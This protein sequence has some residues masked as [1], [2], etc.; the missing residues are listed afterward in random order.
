MVQL[1]YWGLSQVP[2]G[3][4][5]DPTGFF[6]SESHQEALARMEYLVTNHRRVGIL[7]GEPGSGKSLTLEVFA[8]AA[9]KQGAHVTQINLTSLTADEFL[10]KLAVGLGSHPS[11]RENIVS[12]WRRIQDQLATLRYQRI[13]TILLLDDS[14][15]CD[16]DVIAALNRLSQFEQHK[17]SSYSLVVTSKPSHSVLLGERLHELCEIRVELDPFSPEETRTYITSSLERCGRM[18]PVFT[19]EAIELIH[20]KTFGLPRRIN[21]LCDLCLFV[22]AAEK[23]WNVDIET[24]ESVAETLDA[25]SAIQE[26]PVY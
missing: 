13:P 14:D 23:A 22:S 21:Q 6:A 4:H 16:V 11:E 26:T 2:F 18:A 5:V 7:F 24:V 25:K 10:W 3:N 1:E 15:E 17:D 19:D 8:R 12:I 9:K 20:E